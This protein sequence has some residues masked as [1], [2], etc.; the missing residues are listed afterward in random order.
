MKKYNKLMSENGDSYHEIKQQNEEG[1]K[2]KS[3]E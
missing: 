1:E 2:V 3:H